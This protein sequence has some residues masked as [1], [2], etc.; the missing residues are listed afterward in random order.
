M[1]ATSGNQYPVGLRFGAAFALTSQTGVAVPAATSA[2][3]P[4]SG[5]Q[6]Y[7]ANAFNLEYPSPRNIVHPG[8]DRVMA[9]DFLPPIES[10]T[11]TI[12]VSRYDMT[13]NAMLCG[14]STFTEADFKMMPWGTDGQGDEPTVALFLYHQSLNAASKVRNW[15]YYVIP[16]CRCI[17]KP[18]G[19]SPDQTMVTYDVV[20]NPSTTTLWGVALTNAT[21]GALEHGI[22]EGHSENQ[23]WLAAWIGAGASAEA[24]FA[25]TKQAYS[26]TKISA[27]ATVLAGTTTEITTG[28]ATTGV[29]SDQLA[30]T[31]IT[32][33]YELA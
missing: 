16:A 22:M 27:W 32:S 8:D 25:A 28:L 31:I 5:L 21:N 30:T 9:S 1:A 7:G 2:T 6:F 26:A 17:P 15:R 13:L 14:V 18:A 12:E 24:T 20:I 33:L 23:P 4:Y 10:I 19:M 3:V 29:T 11:A